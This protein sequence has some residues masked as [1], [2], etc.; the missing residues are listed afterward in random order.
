ML[1]DGTETAWRKVPDYQGGFLLDGGIH[2]VAALRV[3]LGEEAQP[4]SL[5]GYSALLQ[6]HLP[7]VDTVTSVWQTKTG[8]AGTFHMSFGST[9]SKKEITIIGENGSV[10]IIDDNVVVRKVDGESTEKAFVWEGYGVKPEIAAWAKGIEAGKP[11]PRQSPEQGLA[12]LEI[13]EKMLRS[14]EEGGKPQ[15]LSF[16]I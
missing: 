10:S 15:P 5:A 16:Q 1:I 11:D 3:L 7:P 6:K 14:G 8:I 13:L 2:Q 4:A 12:D 9:Y